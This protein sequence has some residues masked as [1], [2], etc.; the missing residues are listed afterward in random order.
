MHVQKLSVQLCPVSVYVEEQ[1]LW[2]LMQYMQQSFSLAP[3]DDSPLTVGGEQTKTVEHTDTSNARRCYFGHLTLA[4][5]QLYLSM[6][7]VPMNTLPADLVTL[8]REWN[9][10][11]VR[12]EQAAVRLQPFEQFYYFE[13]YAFLFDLVHK[14]YAH[15]LK[16]QALRLFASVDFLGN[17]LGLV[18]DVA[19]GFQV[20]C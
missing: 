19:G 2:R 3:D 1:L 18:E 15:C 4:C 7:T 9:V 11:L 14:H 17:P 8:K 5:P 12:F 20:D 13:T 16:D 6:I 10:P